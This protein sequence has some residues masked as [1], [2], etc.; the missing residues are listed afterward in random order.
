MSKHARTWENYET[1]EILQNL[2]EKCICSSRKALNYEFYENFENSV[3]CLAKLE[4]G[5]IMMELYKTLQLR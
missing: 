2:A 4:N 1:R 3:F 5:T